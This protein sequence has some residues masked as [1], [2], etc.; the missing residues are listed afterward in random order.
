MAGSTFT[1][2]AINT[3]QRIDLRIDVSHAVPH[4]GCQEI[5][6][7]AWLPPAASL[8]QRP[9]AIFA[10][11]GGGYS[12]HYYD[13]RVPGHE[14]Y[15][16]AE[17]HVRNGFIFVAYDHLGVGGSSTEQLRDY[18]VHDLAAAND[19]AVREVTRRLAAGTLSNVLPPVP[20]LVRIGIGQ[21]MGGCLTIV[22]QGR[23]ATF[24][25]IAPLGYSALHTVLP[26]RDAAEQQ[27]GLDHHA[28]IGSRPVAE[29]SVEE[30]SRGVVD[31]VYPFHWEDVPA[32]ILAADMSGGYPLR[33]TAPAWGSLT[34]PPCA[35]TMMTPGV[36]AA[37]AAAVKVPVLV[38]VGE[39]DVCPEPHA[40]PSAYKG[41]NDV[42]LF[43]VPRMAHMH[44]FASTRTQLWSRIESWSRRVASA[45]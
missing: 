11:P 45:Y 31:F 20:D 25:A 35:V 15:S 42:S 44:N 3:M 9:V 33:K 17:A 39:R 8:G 38:G 29:I 22:M 16:Q 24:D 7:T 14:G 30:A 41:S 5:A 10:S 12:R 32:D 26:Q 1:C 18:A 19:A 2:A 36:V 21:S 6:M 13:I 4:P 37:E 28:H 23:H 40:E 27:R 34:V 43:I